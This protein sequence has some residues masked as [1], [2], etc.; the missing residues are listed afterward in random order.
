[1]QLVDLVMRGL[2]DLDEGSDRKLFVPVPLFP[3]NR[4]P[5]PSFTVT[6]ACISMVSIPAVRKAYMS[7]RD[8]LRQKL[9]F[10]ATINS[11]LLKSL[12]T[13]SHPDT[14]TFPRGAISNR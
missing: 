10:F 11:P 2:L 1:M 5:L 13:A 9:S 6:E 7:M 4:N 14:G 12:D 8:L 3:R